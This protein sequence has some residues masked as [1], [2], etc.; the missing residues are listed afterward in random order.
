MDTSREPEHEIAQGEAEADSG[1]GPS[2]STPYALETAQSN[3]VA[4]REGIAL[5]LSGG[6][7]RA[8]LY[9][10]GSV[11]RLNELGILSRVQTISSVSGGSIFA[12]HLA[13]RIRPWPESGQI[14][15]WERRVAE[16]F[17][18]LTRQNI[19]T[20]AF[21]KRLLLP[22]NWFRST[23]VIDAM[24][25]LY[26]RKVTSLKL[27]ELPDHP[28][29][30][31]CA[32]DLNYGVNWESAKTH[33]GDYQAGYIRPAPPWPV[34]RA[35]AA[36]SCAPPAF[37][38]MIVGLDPGLFKRG[39]DPAGPKRDALVKRLQLADGA[40]YDN[41]GLEPVWKH[42]RAVLVSD[43]G[44]PFPYT[45]SR[46]FFARLMRYMGIMGDQALALRKRWLMAGFVNKVMEGSY[47]SVSSAVTSYANPGEPVPPGYSKELAMDYISQIRTDLDA[48]S[49]GEI[50]ILENHGYL[51]T[52]AAIKR[53]VPDLLPESVPPLVIPHPEWMDEAKAREALKNSHRLKLPFG[54]GYRFKFW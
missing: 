4:L 34:A 22:W 53:W 44:A 35:I 39:K 5:C 10:L 8:A 11:R 31:L 38:P 51:L 3:K 45:T 27:T 43:G 19:R 14:P 47:W 33:L 13:D 20:N 25:K 9:H 24:A 28:R 46:A 41:M 30:I 2:S 18:A 50:S 12:G 52:D 48:C 23:T 1:T 54:H 17:R 40:V 7:Y 42:S 16:P 49:E 21:L 6:G 29:F 32:T 37:E 36:S 15:D 26:E